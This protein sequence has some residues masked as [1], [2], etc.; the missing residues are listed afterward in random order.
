MF[1]R[2]R[3]EAPDTT[4][5]VDVHLEW[6]VDAVRQT[7]ID[8]LQDPSDS[9]RQALLAALKRLDSQI[10]LGDAYSESV[11]DSSFFGQAPKGTILG[12]TSS[13]SMAEEVPDAVLRA[14]I[15]LV[16]AAKSANSESEPRCPSGPPHRQRLACVGDRQVPLDIGSGAETNLH[17]AQSARGKNTKT[18]DL[19]CCVRIARKCSGSQSPVNRVRQAW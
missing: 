11:L 9:S 10:D 2:R 15:L 12:E 7:V 14:Q 1:G 6:D 3:R 19:N 5:Q 4:A 16:R 8:F 13:H 17:A 18:P